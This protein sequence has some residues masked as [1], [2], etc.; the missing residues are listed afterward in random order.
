MGPLDLFSQIQEL[1]EY[2]EGAPANVE[3][4]LW[5]VRLDLHAQVCLDEAVS[6]RVYFIDVRAEGLNP[7]VSIRVYII[8]VR[9]YIIDVRVYFIDVNVS[10]FDVCLFYARRCLFYRRR[11]Y[12]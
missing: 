3:C 8:D 4:I 2:C 10:I 11:V 7:A 12:F 9:V 1:C 6:I 5:P